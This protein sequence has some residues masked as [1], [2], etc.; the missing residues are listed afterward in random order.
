LQGHAH[1]DAASRCCHF[2]SLLLFAFT[3][4][5]ETADRIGIAMSHLRELIS[6]ADA[7]DQVEVT[8]SQLCALLSPAAAGEFLPVLALTCA[9]SALT[10]LVGRQEGHPACKN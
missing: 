6:S 8:V 4:V 10:P 9:F 5:Y 3:F 1:S 7:S 2:I